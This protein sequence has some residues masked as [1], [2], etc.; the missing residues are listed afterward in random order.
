MILTDLNL[1]YAIDRC[2]VKPN[3]SVAI[4]VLEKTDIIQ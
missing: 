4:G 2:L 3:F 1:K